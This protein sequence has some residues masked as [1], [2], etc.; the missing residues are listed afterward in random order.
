MQGSVVVQAGAVKLG[1]GP[2]FHPL[3]LHQLGKNQFTQLAHGDGDETTEKVGS[4]LGVRSWKGHDAG[5]ARGLWR[6]YRL[7]AE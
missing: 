1:G 2:S 5:S 4:I 7:Q 3:G 6:I